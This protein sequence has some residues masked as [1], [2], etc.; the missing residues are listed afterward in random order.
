MEDVHELYRELMRDILD[1]AEYVEAG[2]ADPK[3]VAHIHISDRGQS[4]DI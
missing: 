3:H 4:L 1:L 2:S